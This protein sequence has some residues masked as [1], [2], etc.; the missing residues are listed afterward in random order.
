MYRVG[1]EIEY[2][3]GLL[4]TVV[5]VPSEGT[6]CACGGFVI[7]SGRH[8]GFALCW[9]DLETDDDE[10]VWGFHDEDMPFVPTLAEALAQYRL[11]R[12]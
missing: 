8:G 6:A 12:A 11:G 3:N 7:Q 5:A 10:E 1:Q 2:A 9:M 4:A